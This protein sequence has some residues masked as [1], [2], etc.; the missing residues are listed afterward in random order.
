MVFIIK[1]G[2]IFFPIK[3]IKHKNRKAGGKWRGEGDVHKIISFYE[4]IKPAALNRFK[5]PADTTCRF[6]A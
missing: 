6:P 5:G 3:T 2:I 4:T 1:L